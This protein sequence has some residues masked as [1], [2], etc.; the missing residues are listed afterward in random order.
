[1]D[2]SNY[3]A[4]EDFLA[5]ASFHN[6]VKHTN[7]ADV[8][9]WEKWLQDNP[10]KQETALDAAMMVSGVEFRPKVVPQHQV[11]A[12][13]GALQE[14]IDQRSRTKTG[15][16]SQKKI[17]SRKL[18]RIAA[19]IGLLV[20]SYLVV[21]WFFQPGEMTYQ[22][23][24]GEKLE[25]KLS[26]G[27]VVVL[28]A[29]STLK[30]YSNNCREVWIQGEAFFKVEKKPQT[31]AKFLVH[32]DDLEVEVLG[33]AFNV[34]KRT[35]NT[36]VVLEEGSVKLNLNNGS[37]RLM[38]PGDLVSYSARTGSVIEFRNKVRSE[39]HTA[40]KDGSLIFETSLA[41]AMEKIEETYGWSF[42]FLDADQGSRQIKLAVPTK[43]LDLC[44]TA[45]EK[46]L[47]ITIEKAADNQ[48]I[49]KSN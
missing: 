11:E 12:A 22:T 26:D 41:E 1:M 5:D 13:L 34:N 40:W 16:L 20:V 24:Y 3:H 10:T 49:I 6:W 2:K 28:N 37:E 19:G 42:V 33:T 7:E 45:F 4:I 21:Q 27:T 43:N 9:F 30:Y 48:L 8:A 14:K 25:L 38:E 46:A 36:Q 35:D 32:T 23:G 47:D 29:N 17:G 31:G 15:G 18:L 44:I 39:L